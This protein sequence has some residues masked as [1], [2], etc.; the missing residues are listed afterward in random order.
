MCRHSYGNSSFD[1]ELPG[2]HCSIMNIAEK[3]SIVNSFFLYIKDY[4]NF[5]GGKSLENIF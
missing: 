1:C 5:F 3:V 2:F 4:F